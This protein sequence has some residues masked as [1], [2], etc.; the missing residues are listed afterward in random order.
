MKL[1]MNDTNKIGINIPPN[2]FSISFAWQ[3]AS[4][5]VELKNGEDILKLAHILSLMLTENG[6]EHKVKQQ[7][8]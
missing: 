6:I 1:T 2:P 5:T 8:K 7:D 4:V 3:N